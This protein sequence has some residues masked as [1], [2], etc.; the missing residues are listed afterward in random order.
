MNCF[1]IET[2]GD[3]ILRQTTAPISSL[4]ETEIRLDERKAGTCSGDSG[5]PAFIKQNGEY[6]L[7]G[8]TS[9]GSV[10]CNDVGVYTNALHFRPWIARVIKLFNGQ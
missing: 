2:D 10:L 7:F 9:R 5:G 8:V 6:Y 1:E 3:G 4:Y